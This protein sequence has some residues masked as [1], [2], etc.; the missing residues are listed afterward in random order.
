MKLPFATELP[1]S[2]RAIGRALVPK[3]FRPALAAQ[4]QHLAHR[5]ERRHPQFRHSLERLEAMRESHRGETCVI[6][7]NGPSLADVDLGQFDGLT[8]F[9][10]NRGYLKWNE[11]GM[12]PTYAVAVNDLVI[13]QF[14]DE[15]AALACPVFVPWQYHHLFDGHDNVIFIEARWQERFFKDIRKGVW[16]GATVTFAAMQIAYFMGFT[17]VILVGVDH[18]FAQAGPAHLEVVQDK[19]DVDHFAKDYF[20]PGVRWNLPD[21]EQ[22]EL[23]YRLARDVYEAEARRIVDAT[24]DGALTVFPKMPLDAALAEARRSA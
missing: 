13:E 9:C 10:L 15:L 23:S 14:H 22:S 11:D 8:T 21:L 12:T 18:R 17:N 16:P 4:L 19:H 5:Q 20:G 6:L 24:K 3:R 2:L 1:T 7:G